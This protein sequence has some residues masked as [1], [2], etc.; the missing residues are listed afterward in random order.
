MIKTGWTGRAVLKYTLLQ[1][2]GTLLVG[3]LLWLVRIKTGLDLWLLWT[4][5]IIWVAKDVLLFFFLWPAYD[6]EHADYYG[7]KGLQ[8]RVVKSLAPRG[9]I[10]VRGQTWKARSDPP[11]SIPAGSTVRVVERHGLTLVV[12]Q[13]EDTDPEIG[14]AHV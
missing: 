2:P 9:T 8:G 6:D 7:L 14:R 1:I 13:E 11:K 10:R 12:R 4:G 3:F 5:L